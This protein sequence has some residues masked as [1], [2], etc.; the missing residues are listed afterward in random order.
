MKKLR[1]YDL[2][3][4]K[5]SRCPKELIAEADVLRSSSLA[6]VCSPLH[7]PLHPTYSC[8]VCAFEVC[9]SAAQVVTGTLGLRSIALGREGH[10]GLRNAARELE[11]RRHPRRGRPPILEIFEL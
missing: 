4:S 7:S 11:E 9:F 5:N 2:P 3:Y 8:R 6:T 10:N 1:E